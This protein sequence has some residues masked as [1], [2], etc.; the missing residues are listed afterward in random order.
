M[1]RKNDAPPRGNGERGARGQDKPESSPTP[2]AGQAGGFYVKFARALAPLGFAI[3]AIGD[4]LTAWWRGGGG[5]RYEP[6]AWTEAAQF[7]ESVAARLDRQDGQLTRLWLACEAAGMAP[8]L[9][10]AADPYGVPVIASGGF[11]SVTA[12][13]ELACELVRFGRAEVLHI[14][15]LDPSGVHLFAS[16]AEDVTAMIGGLGGCP[17]TFSRLAVTTEQ[18]AAM[19]LPT[20]P[21]QPTDPRR[22]EGATVQAEAIPPDVLSALVVDAIVSRQN[23]EIRA[24]MLG[25][26]Q[27]L[28][29][30]LAAW[31]GRAAE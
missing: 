30:E 7:R 22:F 5:D 9:A 18:V 3:V 21:P 14:G 1:P 24:E 11:D 20:A 16:L 12:K 28:R 31:V 27:A 15:D 23:A 6:G 8:Q 2:R 25:R 26:E 29:A 13:H 10:E 19:G 4:N 17:P